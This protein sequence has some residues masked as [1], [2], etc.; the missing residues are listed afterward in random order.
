MRRGAMTVRA[1]GTV[2]NLGSAATVVGLHG[3]GVGRS[4]GR[5]QRGTTTAGSPH[6]GQ[7]ELVRPIPRAAGGD[8]PRQILWACLYPTRILST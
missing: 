2:L 8:L 3:S 5:T 7:P 6:A 1:L 4:Q